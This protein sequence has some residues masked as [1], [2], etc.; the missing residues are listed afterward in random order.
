[1]L[2]YV[3]CFAAWNV[4]QVVVQIDDWFRDGYDRTEFDTELDL[5]A[6]ARIQAPESRMRDG[7][8]PFAIAQH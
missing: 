5:T 8:R 1:M 7:C 2:I 6:Q 3:S 4:G